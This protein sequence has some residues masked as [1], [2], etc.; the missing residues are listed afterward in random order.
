MLGS[1]G[2]LK[3]WLGEGGKNPKSSRVCTQGFS[4]GDEGLEFGVGSVFGGVFN[5]KLS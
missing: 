4:A 3:D 2:I 1:E 5:A